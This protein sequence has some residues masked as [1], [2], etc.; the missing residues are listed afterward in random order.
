MYYFS[1]HKYLTLRLM[2]LYS[3]ILDTAHPTRE[4]LYSL[5][6]FHVFKYIC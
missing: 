1:V 5:Y 6:C 2:N 4:I 3:F